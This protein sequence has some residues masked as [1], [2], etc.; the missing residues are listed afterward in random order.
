[1]ESAKHKPQIEYLS[2]QLL[3]PHPDN[4]RTHSRKQIKQIAKSIR[5][6]GFRGVVLIDE[7][8]MIIVGH[9]RVKASKLLGLTEIPV[10]RISDLTGDQIR[11]LMIA[12]NK[13]TDNSEWDDEFLGQ[14]LKILADHDLDF[15]IEV[16]GFDYG[17]IEVRISQIE[18]S[19]QGESGFEE[20]ASVVPDIDQ[21]QAVSRPGDLWYLDGHRLIC[22]NA[23]SGGTYERLMESERAAVVFTDPPYNL[24]A[25]DIG[26]V[27]AESHGDFAMGAGEMTRE[28]FTS[29]LGLVMKNLCRF[30]LSGSIQYLCMDW[31]HAAEMLEAG[32]AHY[33]E[34][35]NLC[36]WAKDRAGMGSFY[37]SQHEL[38]FV[39]KHGDAPHQNH[40]EL[41]QHGR[42]RSNVWQFPG[43]L[44]FKAKDGDP[45]GDEALQLHPT[46][47]P[48]K[49]IEEALLDC[50]RR[51]E[52][53]LD[54]FLGSGSTLIAAEKTYRRCFGLEIEPRYADVTIHRWQKWTGKEA[55]EATTGRTYSEVLTDRV[56]SAAVL[57]GGS[58]SE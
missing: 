57:E 9:A 29:F 24:P 46:V 42:T 7:N 38:V 21:I 6:F 33:A 17:E 2:P 48:V 43:V 45:D 19:E 4:P 12:D 16:L 18:L 11:G 54:P 30:S 50:S 44:Q 20:D 25:R 28:A 5:A 52:I 41:G 40:F 15:D 39:F 49:L 32:H 37:R 27:C 22:G 58:V 53:V 56:D 10:L 3:R 8:S 47:K 55:V 1:M 35:K 36:V 23:T 13:L 51:G 14:N 34:F 26:K 31:R